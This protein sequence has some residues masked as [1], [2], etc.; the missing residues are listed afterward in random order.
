MHDEE[1]KAAALAS[2]EQV[3]KA[4]A[5]VPIITSMTS[6]IMLMSSTIITS[7]TTSITSMNS[8]SIMAKARNK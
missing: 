1:Q 6:I 4:R 5:T 7:I 8:I 3:T 2:V